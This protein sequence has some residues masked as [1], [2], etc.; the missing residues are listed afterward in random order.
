M[1][2][3]VWDEFLCIYRLAKITGYVYMHTENMIM[4]SGLIRSQ[5]NIDVIQF[6]SGG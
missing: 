2:T 5:S 3:L 6:L 4:I 1:V